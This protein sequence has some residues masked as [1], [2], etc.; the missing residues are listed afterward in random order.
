[1]REG[2]RALVRL[3]A[4][5]LRA[6]S[7]RCLAALRLPLPLRL[8]AR[9]LEP[10]LALNVEKEVRKDALVIASSRAEI[11]ALL[12]RAR[13]IDRE[14]VARL[15]LVRLEIRYEEI[16][17]IRARRMETLLGVTER[18]LQ[19]PWR[20]IRIAVRERYRPEPFEALLREHLRLYAAEVHALARSVR[21]AALLAPVHEHL[22]GSM[23]REANSLA[24]EVTRLL[25]A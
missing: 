25:Y 9:R 20:G 11:P 7:R 8:A 22:R 19:G 2:V 6:Y 15:P 14:F 23:E 5:L 21:L 24:R 13:D 17:P 10:V 12:R 18:L 1:V 3:N 4:W 16:E